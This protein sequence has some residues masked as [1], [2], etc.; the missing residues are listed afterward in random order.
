MKQDSHVPGLIPRNHTVIHP[1]PPSPCSPDMM[2]WRM[3]GCIERH[4]MLQQVMPGVS[5]GGGNFGPAESDWWTIRYVNDAIKLQTIKQR[6]E[7][8]AGS[9]ASGA[10]GPLLRL[11]KVRP[12]IP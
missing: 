1:L 11:S 7:G 4:V 9:T 3:Q 8:S 12:Q 10:P 2:A 5:A 6:L